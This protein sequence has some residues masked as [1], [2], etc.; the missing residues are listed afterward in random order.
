MRTRTDLF[1][2]QGASSSLVVK[3]ADTEKERQLRRMQQMAGNMGLLN[4]F[5]FNQ[6]GSYGT[7][8]QV[9]GRAKALYRSHTHTHTHPPE[10]FTHVASLSSPKYAPLNSQFMQQQAALVAATSGQAAAGGTYI[11]PLTSGLPATAAAAA[12]A[13]QIAPALNGLTSAAVV[14]PTSGKNLNVIKKTHQRSMQK[15]AQCLL[16]TPFPA[17]FS[18]FS[19]CLPLRKPPGD[20]G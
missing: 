20:R 11:S 4:P 9:R 2:F 19:P 12:A 15:T 14:T 13:A 3:F 17:Y 18:V 7:Y 10:C 5:V 1:V 16:T 8:A 6:F